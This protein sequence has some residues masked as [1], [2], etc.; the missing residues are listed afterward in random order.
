M[1]LRNTMM[2]LQRAT[3]EGIPVKGNFYWSAMQPAAFG[4]V[5]LLGLLGFEPRTKGL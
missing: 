4:L 5:L 2:H 3:S 1:Y